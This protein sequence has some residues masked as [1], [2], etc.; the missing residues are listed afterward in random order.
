M[1][2][3]TFYPHQSRVIE[4][5]I[6]K[7][8]KT[9]LFIMDDLWLSRRLVFEMIGELESTRS[10][11]VENAVDIMSVSSSKGKI[12]INDIRNIRI[13]L[14]SYPVQWKRKY[15]VIF[16]AERITREGANSF[17]KI[18]EEPEKFNV[19]IMTT[20][21]INAV[22]PTIRSR[23][24]NI[25]LNRPDHNAI[26]R[27][28]SELHDPELISLFSEIAKYDMQIFEAIEDI[29]SMKAVY[30]NAKME[31]NKDV[32]EVADEFVKF[33]SESDWKGCIIR[34][35]LCKILLAHLQGGNLLSNLRIM[36]SLLKKTRRER[37]KAMK[38]LSFLCRR[39]VEK[40]LSMIANDEL[41]LS[42]KQTKAMS[43]ITELANWHSVP[44][45]LSLAYD[46]FAIAFE[47]LKDIMEE[48]E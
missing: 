15:A 17:L 31:T 11:L 23:A 5:S 2:L 21:N 44:F 10:E 37:E 30:E 42:D 39:T 4:D 35:Q 8:G 18:T 9:F 46:R 13:F 45:S 43:Y 36:E 6:R 34:H 32:E 19:I 38:T 29:E 24:M 33:I 20:S 28:A 22:L 48:H 3:L 7:E 40:T 16:G 14:K 26:Q 41:A 47:G 27:I 1:K 25:T 12:L